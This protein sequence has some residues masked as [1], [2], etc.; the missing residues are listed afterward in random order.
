MHS[1]TIIKLICVAGPLAVGFGAIGW[2]QAADVGQA[3]KPVIFDIKHQPLASALN[4]FAVQS[5]QQILFTPEVAAGR[6]SRGI[7]GASAPDVAL[8]QIL[9][10]TGLVSS[11]ST[12]G[13]ILV[14]TADAKEA[15]AKSDPPLAP[16]GA[17]NEER[18]GRPR[19]DP[20][21]TTASIEEI[22]VTATKR[23]QLLSDVPLAVQ[24]VT[25]EDLYMLGARS[26]SDYSRTL[27]GVQVMDVGTGRDQIFIRGV[28]APQGYIG[29]ESAVGVYLD[30]VPIS[31]G[32]NQPDLN[33]YDVDRIEVLRG[34]QG[35]LYGSASL[36]GTIRIITN[37]PK[38]DVVEGTFDTE[39]S[40]TQHGGFNPAYSAT[41]NLPIVSDLMAVRGVIYG[42]NPSG[43]IDDPTLG[44]TGVND[45]D[46]YG[47][48]LALRVIPNDRLT[49]DLKA[50]DQ[51]TH[52][53]GDNFADSA[54]GSYVRLDQYRN[55][56]EPFI[57]SSQIYNGTIAYGAPSFTVNSSTSFSRR[58]R[59]I[60]NDFTGL[61]FLGDGAVTPSYQRYIAES[62]TQELR[63]SSVQVK[64]F[65]WLVGAYFN[66]TSDNFFQSIDS[67]GA[68]ALF[69]LPSD[70]VAQ[71]AQ[72]S[73]DKQKALFGEI[74]YSPIDRLTLTGGIRVADLTLDSASLRDGLLIGAVLQNAGT[75]TQH[76][77]APKA[78]IS[79]NFTPDTLAYIQAAKGYRIGGVNA[80]IQTLNG[81]VFPTSYRPDSLWNYEVG[82]K[83]TALSRRLSFDADVFYIDWKN[84]QLDLQQSGIDYFANA[85]NALSQGVEL[86]GALQWTDHLQVG[87]QVTYTDAKL[88]ST[89]PGVGND[90][91]RVP[92]VP[93]FS[94][95]VFAEYATTTALGRAYARLDTQYVGTAFTGFGEIGN[96][97]YGD[98]GLTN[99]KIGLDRENWRVALFGKNV[100]DRRA[101]LFAQPYYAG[102]INSP[103]AESVTVARP[104]TVGVDFTWLF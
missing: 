7:Q 59:D 19:S 29:M 94:G 79:W 46:T 70:N 72:T 5:H 87:G 54:G 80:T 69:G 92:F 97:S 39:F 58:R 55:I 67:V 88:T 82:F 37:Q 16:N 60:N 85:G 71:L 24:A 61:N 52:Q 77:S 18:Q 45:E 83:G 68:G 49:I 27:A 91:E 9:A 51:H 73:T 99:V 104:R 15:S 95:S 102:V 57:D 40:G 56:P 81:F 90:G 47:G 32:M 103:N 13:M 22:V 3:P 35:T 1:R 12:D 36:G 14:T 76:A 28:A 74:G 62:F 41:L 17:T 31:E 65:S 53:G 42:R 101:T 84:I 89:T 23:S 25:A 64:P 2:A 98:Y 50:M 33:L 66:R 75:T 34:P 78:N 86:Q 44:K 26:F 93:R 43:F 8:A 96:Y 48:R 20:A 6:T 21:A 100:F 10:G 38:I 63:V 30:D 11:R 4:A